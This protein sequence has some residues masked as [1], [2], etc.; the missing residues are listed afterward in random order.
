AL[1]AFGVVMNCWSLWLNGHLTAQADSWHMLAP[2]FVRACGLGFIFV[3]LSVVAL[4][5]LP[6]RQRGNAAGLFNLTRELGGSSGTAAMSTILSR[7]QKLHFSALGAHINPFNDLYLEQAG[8]L[9][10]SLAGRVT[11]PSATA[12]SLFN[13]RVSMQS[14]VLAF[15]DNFMLLTGI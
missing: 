13:L 2:I 10:T 1:I 12:L 14:L 6:P 5:D 9:R 15:R 7:Q 11:D 8:A 3:P 4:S